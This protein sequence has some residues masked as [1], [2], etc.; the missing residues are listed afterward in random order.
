MALK[1]SD[2]YA[3][4]R[5]GKRDAYGKVIKDIEDIITDCSCKGQLEVWILRNYIDE[6][7]TRRDEQ[8]VNEKGAC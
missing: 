7:K 4:Y 6:L 1:P 5:K 3:R 2:Y 8:Q